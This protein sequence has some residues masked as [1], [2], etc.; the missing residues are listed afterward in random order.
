MVM[1]NNK[2]SLLLLVALALG[3]AWDALF[4]DK[5]LGVSV[6]LFVCLFL[7]ALFGLG[8]L[9]GVR[10]RWGNLWLLAP[11]FFFAV[12]VFVRAD[13]L[14]I[15]FNVMTIL[16]LLGLLVHFFGGGRLE[17]LG[18]VGYPLVLTQTALAA[19][20]RPPSL[21]SAGVDLGAVRRRGGSHLAPVA[22]G[23]LLALPVLTVFTCCLASA[24]EVFADYVS[25]LF[26]LEF[27]P[28]LGE[29]LWRGAMI[30]AVA[31]V[32]AGSLA[33]AIHRR[34]E[35]DKVLAPEKAFD[36]LR[37]TV[38]LGF[39]EVTTLLTSVD[40]LF[41]VFV[42]IQFTY[43][44]G[45]RTNI[46]LEGYTYAE[47]ARRGFFELLLVSLMALGL[48]LILYH[49]TRRDTARQER[50]FILL[51]SLMILFV[52]VILASAFQRLMLYEDA[53]GYTRLRLYGHVFMLWLGA[54]FG[55][56]LVLL[57]R[58]SGRFA[59]GVFVAAIGFLVTLNLIN[60]D[61][62]IAERNLARYQATGKLDVYY[63]ITLSDDA[64][65]ALLRARDQLRGESRR[66]LDNYLQRRLDEL[67][68]DSRWR[69]WPAFHLGR[70]RAYDEL[71]ASQ[72]R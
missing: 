11:L 51:S 54:V 6:L 49:L 32:V 23:C 64:V 56:F 42:W 57:W 70:Y 45:G 69:A 4:Y 35:P 28:H 3:W 50:L 18:L 31:W 60:P 25:D 71:L 40:L 39:V 29:W 14:L 8:A 10:P 53:F 59:I 34:E 38:R 5:P 58:R 15:L 41:L 33:C 24:D 65:P 36:D 21:V 63:L 20:A 47:Y 52:L 61:A 16:L 66:M 7:A 17:R 62:L 67:K 55:W 68:T 9:A 72:S 26:H 22:R 48:I 30:G 13:P 1:H 27:L 2:Y 46:T 12:M 44:F 43:L 19:L 37:Q